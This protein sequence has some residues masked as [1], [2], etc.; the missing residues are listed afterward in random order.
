M[1]AKLY[2]GFMTHIVRMNWIFAS[3]SRLNRSLIFESAPRSAASLCRRVRRSKDTIYEA[4]GKTRVLSAP[5]REGRNCAHAKV[6]N[7][8]VKIYRRE[9]KQYQQKNF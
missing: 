7:S 4:L 9:A 1:L 3:R 8:S 5:T 2:L 6:G